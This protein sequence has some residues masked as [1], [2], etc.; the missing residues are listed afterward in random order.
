M[1]V[2]G[3][4]TTVRETMCMVG[5]EQVMEF[6][7]DMDGKKYKMLQINYHHSK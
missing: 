2:C 5:M 1:E 6:C 4:N 3:G 7:R